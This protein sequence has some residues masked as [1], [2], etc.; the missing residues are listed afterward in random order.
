M[1][2]HNRNLKICIYWKLP[3]YL[4]SSV[5]NF[6]T[7]SQ[8]IHFQTIFDLCSSTIPVYCRETYVSLTT[9]RE[10][11][12]GCPECAGRYIGMCRACLFASGRVRAHTIGI[13]RMSR[14]KP[15]GTSGTRRRLSPL[16]WRQFPIA[17]LH[18]CCKYIDMSL[19]LLTLC[20]K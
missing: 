17:Q 15:I 14:P 12:F 4:K 7:S 3:K 10:H 11:L 5:W 1:R 6:G 13:S 9:L 2:T 18:F 16:A 8:T 20:T 19:E